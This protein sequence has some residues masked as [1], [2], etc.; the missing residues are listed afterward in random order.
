MRLS[1]LHEGP[2]WSASDDALRPLREPGGRRSGP[3]S[4]MPCRA[5][6]GLHALRYAGHNPATVRRGTAHAA[7]PMLFPLASTLGASSGWQVA[8]A[9]F[10]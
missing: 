8:A 10:A 5:G 1:V 9:N 6:G 3:Q 2:A 4:G 7:V